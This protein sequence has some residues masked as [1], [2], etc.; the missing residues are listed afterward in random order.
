MKSREELHA[1]WRNPEP[2]NAP[3]T[4]VN[5]PERT[6]YLVG[7]LKERAHTSE[8]IMELG[9]NVGRNLKGLYDAGFSNLYGVE[10]NLTALAMMLHTYPEVPAMVY[11]GAIE[12]LLNPN[13]LPACDVVFTMCVLM[14]LHPDSEWVFGEIANHTDTRS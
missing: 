10:I 4:Y 6:E 2:K 14:H 9:C 1:Y 13:H 7:L 3:E 11:T 12:D 5:Y 8:S